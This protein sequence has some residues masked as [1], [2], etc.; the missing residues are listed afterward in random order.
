[1]TTYIEEKV[2]VPPLNP[3]APF[4]I[5]PC[6]CSKTSTE[7]RICIWSCSKR[8][9][10]DCNSFDTSFVTIQVSWVFLCTIV[11]TFRTFNK[12]KQLIM[13]TITNNGYALFFPNMRLKIRVYGSSY[14]RTRTKHALTS[15]HKYLR[16]W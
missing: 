4:K 13:G 7:R 12:E 8:A 11:Y 2:M 1:M 16:T 6:R 14:K 15:L 3:G 9:V 5:P 10:Q